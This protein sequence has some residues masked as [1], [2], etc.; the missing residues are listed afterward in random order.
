MHWQWSSILF[1]H[2][3]FVLFLTLAVNYD[4]YKT[5][6]F[7]NFPNQILAHDYKMLFRLFGYMYHQTVYLPG[8]M[9]I[10]MAKGMIVVTPVH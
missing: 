10:S 6:K 8:C 5:A 2:T 3:T 7:L 1:A 4:A 9:D